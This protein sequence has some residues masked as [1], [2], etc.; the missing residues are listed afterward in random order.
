[1]KKYQLVII[2]SGPGGYV[3]GEYASKQ[4]LHTLV[5]ESDKFGG[6]CLNKGCIP[7]KTLLKSSKIIDYVSHA[8]KYGIDG[9]DINSISLN[10]NKIQERKNQVVKQLQNGI[11]GLLKMAK[12]DVINGKANVL[13]NN[14]LEVNGEIIEF[15]KLIVATGSTPRKLNLDGF[16]EGYKNNKIITSDEA[17][18]LDSIPK[19]F[20]VIGGGVIGIEFATLYAGLGSEVTILQGV[21]RILEVLDND[22][23]K[24][25]TSLLQKSNVKILT[26]VKISKFENNKIYFEHEGETKNIESD[27]TLVSVGRVPT[28]DCVNNIQIDKANNGSIITNEYME[29]SIKNIYAIGDCTSKIML[30]HTAHK[31]ALVAVDRILGKNNKYDPLKIPSCI[32]TYPEVASIGKTEEELIKE[33][34]QYFKAKTPMNHIGKALADGESSGFLK[35]LVSKECGEILGCH[36]VASTASDII[37]EIALAM[38]L[39]A[40]IYDLTN[41]IHPHPTVSEIVWETA[42]KIFVENF[43][44]KKW[45]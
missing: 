40:T 37:S 9:I 41:T 44:D 42:R 2:G 33:N 28:T 20:T 34:I 18:T 10:W 22:I 17:L 45:F 12:V 39:E 38:E 32:Y 16:E 31:N 30:A 14:T 5:I 6:V 15:E 29:T 21:D 11:G 24:E 26:N 13:T 3:A 43:K 23:S 36:I 27:I 19:K 7:T 8:S 1:M 25:I 35:L 4:G